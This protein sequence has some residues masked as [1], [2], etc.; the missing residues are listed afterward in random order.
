M[1]SFV[2]R[3]CSGEATLASN[4][5]LPFVILASGTGTNARA[6][7]EAARSSPEILRCV[8]LVSDRPGVG[9]LEIAANFGV[10]TS[11]IP[12]NSEAKL[13]EFLRQKEARWACLAGYKRIVPKDFLD[14]FHD[15]ALGFSRV[16]NVHPSLLPAYP[17]LHGYRRA[18]ADGVKVA[19]VTV[20]LVDG[21]LDTGHVI[22]Q[23]AFAREEADD[24]AA[25]TAKGRAIEL[26]LF[27]AALRLA[28][29]NRIRL[30]AG[31]KSR[32]VSLEE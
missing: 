23:R 27:P 29:E 32:W 19:G 21:G 8:G 30:R 7:L 17:G 25:F 16:M 9:A 11:V 24:E 28:A 12:A 6:L 22:L 13:L 5:S 3:A 4:A 31:E 10:E 1:K 2:L 14:F 15:P 20:H 18:F 26:E